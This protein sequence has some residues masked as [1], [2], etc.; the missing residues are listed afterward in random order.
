M[1][2]KNR[3]IELNGISQRHGGIRVLILI[4]KNLSFHH[5]SPSSFKYLMTDIHQIITLSTCLQ[6][7]YK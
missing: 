2:C 3:S 4:L 7:E 5:L 6:F 1:S